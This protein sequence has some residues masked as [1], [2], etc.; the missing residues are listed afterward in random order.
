ME[1]ILG[2]I[3]G[4]MPGPLIICIGA[5]HGNEQIGLHAFRNVLSA[6]QNHGIPFR[7]K[8]VGIAGNIKAIMSNDRFIDYDLNRVWEDPY[9]SSLISSNKIKRAEDDELIALHHFIEKESEGVYT[10][11]I[12][13]DLHATSSDK[14]NFVVVPSDEASHPVVQA[15]KLPVVIN[16]DKFLKGTLLAYYHARGYLSFAFEGGIIGTDEAYQLHTSGLWEI[17]DKSGAITHHD[18]EVEDHYLNHLESVSESLP[19]LVAAIYRHQIKKGDGFHMLPGFHNFQP[20][21]KG[22]Q[23]A[24]DATGPILCP[25]DGLIFM[26]L[27]QH[28]GEDGFFI[29]EEVI[30][31]EIS[32]SS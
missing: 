17:L 21:K 18:H 2:R 24:V 12:I 31:Q 11:K 7:G 32:F 26:P 6:I 8:L 22:Q 1:R 28:A 9:V 23:L 25:A 15:I 27:Y 30:Q 13:V 19:H 4:D 16:L 10:E 20:V 14:G 5:L 29:V 3:E